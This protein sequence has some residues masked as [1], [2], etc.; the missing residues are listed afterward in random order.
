MQI[1][2]MWKEFIKNWFKFWWIDFK[3]LILVFLM[4]FNHVSRWD[5]Y[6]TVWMRQLYKCVVKDVHVVLSDR[7]TAVHELKSTV[8]LVHMDWIKFD[9]GKTQIFLNKLKIKLLIF[10]MALY[11]LYVLISEGFL[12]VWIWHCNYL[13]L[14]TSQWNTPILCCVCFWYWLQVCG[15]RR[16]TMVVN[17]TVQCT[18]VCVQIQGGV[19]HLLHTYAE[20]ST[21][22]WIRSWINM[23]DI[24]RKG[25]FPVV[26]DTGISFIKER[27]GMVSSSHVKV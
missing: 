21:L 25:I 23:K 27:E 6:V 18:Y 17:V 3:I 22:I 14:N 24:V 2:M 13:M 20:T 12:Y 9:W 16:V 10:P 7:L 8:S 19:K 11:L 26:A 1:D 4:L 5:R 15:K